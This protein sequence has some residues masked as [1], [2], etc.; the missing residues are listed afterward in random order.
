MAARI[1]GSL[2]PGERKDQITLAHHE[3]VAGL[4]LQIGE[5]REVVDLYL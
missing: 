5:I 1:V 2:L 4:N 3:A